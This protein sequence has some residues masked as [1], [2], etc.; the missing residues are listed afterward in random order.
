MGLKTGVM[1]HYRRLSPTTS[2]KFVFFTSSPIKRK[3]RWVAAKDVT[4]LVSEK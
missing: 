4:A 2:R 3:D 1:N